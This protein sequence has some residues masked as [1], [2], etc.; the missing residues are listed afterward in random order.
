LYAS[1]DIKRIIKSRYVRQGR[2]LVCTGNTRNVYKIS[3]GKPE[4]KKPLGRSRSRR[5][6][7]KKSDTNMWTGSTSLRTEIRE[8]FL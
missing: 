2:H 8:V 1:P 7:L 3:V 4:G 6:I 5:K